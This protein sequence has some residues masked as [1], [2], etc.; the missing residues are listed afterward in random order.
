MPGTSPKRIAILLNRDFA[1][2]EIG[3]LSATARDFFSAQLDYLTPNGE[4]V[5]SEG[6]MRV[7]SDGSF[8]RAESENFDAL[9]VC[10]SARW[11]DPDAI[12]IG[13]AL[14]SADQRGAAIG[15]ICAGT[16]TAARAGL[17]R[18]RMHTS[19]GAD[20]IA[21]RLPNYAGR[22]HYLQSQRAVLDSG[23]VSAPS[24]APASFAAELLG[25][26]YPDRPELQQVRTMLDG[27]R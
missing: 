23:V 2:W 9:V 25:L 27:V 16:L 7:A 15:V 6:G 5:L 11:S 24:N 13:A 12:D 4:G 19:N 22:H 1:D 3:F 21:Q 17:F 8:A 10:G 14:R 20:W 18:N 26:L